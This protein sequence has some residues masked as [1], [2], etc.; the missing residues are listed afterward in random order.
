MWTCCTISVAEIRVLKKIGKDGLLQLIIALESEKLSH[1]TP[2][3]FLFFFFHYLL[4]KK[5]SHVSLPTPA[6]P[7]RISYVHYASRGTARVGDGENQPL[8]IL[9][10]AFGVL[11]RKKMGGKLLFP[12]YRTNEN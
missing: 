6:L 3:Y 12:Y 9:M 11:F 10:V 4:M 2:S 5:S 7:L 1:T 8:V